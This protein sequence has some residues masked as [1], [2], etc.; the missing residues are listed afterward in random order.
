MK[1]HVQ[2]GKYTYGVFDKNVIWDSEAWN[3]EGEKN[4]LN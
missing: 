4:N 2:I 1:E 3:Y